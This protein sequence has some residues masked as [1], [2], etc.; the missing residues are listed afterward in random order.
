MGRPALND[1]AALAVASAVAA[2]A[3]CAWSV[4]WWWVAAAGGVA[5]A[6]RRP[7]AVV[8][9]LGILASFLAARAWDGM[10]PPEARTLHGA[11]TL[12]RDPETVRG[13]VRAEVRL[14]GRH[15]DAWARGTD[16]A[17]LASR[18]AGDRVD[19]AGRVGG[20]AVPGHLRVRHVVARLDL[21]RVARID[22]GS[23]LARAANAV[24]RT[25]VR[26]TSGM[27]REQRSLFTGLVIGDDREQ[28]LEVADDFRGAG[29]THLLAVSGQNV[30]FVLAAAGPLLRRLGWRARVAATLAVLVLFATIT[31]Y[32]PSVLRA[33]VMAGL[34]CVAAAVGRPGPALRVLAL[35][36]TALVLADPF[37]VRSVGFG[38]SVG[39]SL[40]ILLLARRVNDVLPGPD[41]LTTPIGVIVAAQLGVAP[42][43]LVVFGR[44]PVASLPANLLAEP[45]AGLVMIWGAS[46]GL[47]AGW[48]PP[49]VAD[50]LHGP[51][52]VM[53]WWVAAVARRG[54]D[55]QL[56]GLDA[57]GLLA[58]A[59]LGG[60]AARQR[61]S[62]PTLARAL[63]GAAL[64][65]LLVPAAVARLPAPDVVE[66]A[67]AGVLRREHDGTVLALADDAYPATALRALRERGVR[68][69]VRIEL[70]SRTAALQAVVALVERRVHVDA[71]V[72]PHPSAPG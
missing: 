57:V 30:A 69:L 46:A 55:A 35:A 36:V 32:E 48:C 64:V 11:A 39:A 59:V 38:L 34:V 18:L 1:R 5:V 45:V 44:L 53:L 26:G 47:L 10:H 20:G 67:G 24:R 14:G 16:A 8:V 28:P 58:V 13:A 12:V 71:V 70:P 6:L 65:A 33:T 68:H 43:A 61:T 40:G 31:R 72:G 41:W 50:A 52:G 62:R 23:P 42:I 51:T 37:L 15:Y 7:A 29:L 17:A 2:G 22:G 27:G 25:L 63:A 66:V 56:G 49:V 9:A 60:A 54:A 21:E 4:T 19:V 3:W